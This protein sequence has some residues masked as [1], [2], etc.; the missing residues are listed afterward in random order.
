MLDVIKSS[1]ASIVVRGNLYAA[2][3]VFLSFTSTDAAVVDLTTS[4]F[5]RSMAAFGQ[6]QAMALGA[7]VGLNRSAIRVDSSADRMENNTQV[8][9]RNHGGDKLLDILCRDATHTGL[10]QMVALSLLDVLT[11]WSFRDAP[12]HWVLEYLHAHNYLMY[13]V[14]AVDELQPQLTYLTS[15]EDVAPD[16]LPPLFIYESLMALLL[17]LSLNKVSCERLLAVN[18]VG[19]LAEGT[20]L[21][22]RV[23]ANL[24][25]AQGVAFVPGASTMGASFA[26]AAATD[27]MDWPVLDLVVTVSSVLPHTPGSAHVAAVARLVARHQHSLVRIVRACVNLTQDAARAPAEDNELEMALLK[28]TAQICRIIQFLAKNKA[29]VAPDLTELMPVLFMRCTRLEFARRDRPTQAEKLVIQMVGNI[30]GYCLVAVSDSQAAATANG[31]AAAPALGSPTR[32]PEVDVFAPNASLRAT[33]AAASNNAAPAT[34]DR[35]AVLFDPDLSTRLATGTRALV[36]LLSVLDRMT[37][38]TEVDQLL[39]TQLLRNMLDVIKSSDASIVV[40]GNLY[41]ALLVF[42][43]FTSTDAAVV[44]LTTSMFSRSMAAFGQSQAMALGASVGLN[45]SAIRVDSSADRME[46]NTQVLLRNHGGDKLLDIL[47]RDATHTGLWQMVALSLLDVLTAWSFRDAPRHW[48]LEYLHAHN[49]LMYFVRAV[50]E[51]QPQLTYLTSSEDVAP[52][53]LP[54]LFIYESLMALLLRLSLN[55]VSPNVGSADLC[56]SYMTLQLR[57]LFRSRST[58]LTPYYPLRGKVTFQNVVFAYD[59]RVPTLR[60][61]SFDIPAGKTVGSSGSGKSTILRLLFRFYDVQGGRILIDGVD[62]R[63]MAQSDLRSLIGVV[64]Q[65]TTAQICRIIQFLA[66]NKA[67]VAPDLTELMPVLFM[68]CT[69]LEFARRDRPTQAEKLVIQMVGNIVGYCLVAVSDS[70]AAAT[71]N[72]TAAAPALGSPT[73]RPEVDVFAPNASLRATAAAA[74]NNAAPA[75]ADRPAVLFDPDLST[76]TRDRY[77]STSTRPTLGLLVL[78]MTQ[79]VARV[80]D[81]RKLAQV[82]EQKLR[83]DPA[84]LTVDDWRAYVADMPRGD[85]THQIAYDVIPARKRADV[86]RRAMQMRLRDVGFEAA[87]N[88]RALEMAMTV[89]YLHVRYYTSGA[90]SAALANS[91][92]Q[93]APVRTSVFGETSATAWRARASGRLAMDLNSLRNDAST[94]VPKLKTAIAAIPWAEEN[95]ARCAFLVH[96]CNVLLERIEAFKPPAE[97]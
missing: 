46:N 48:V 95:D 43:S 84:R 47:C 53:E 7:S 45:R 71:A 89:L 20:F 4:M 8:L 49:Y 16:E 37:A 12:R 40:R 65:D 13:F 24:A 6:S 67:N 82:L 54:P 68:R 36:L 87:S 25:A 83:E 22:Y 19:K 15:S 63:H 50:D 97:L 64:P 2:L 77:Y 23:G 86:I 1:D 76:A 79:V 17:R 57:R 29:N 41:A 96:L 81:A 51:L 14:R 18:A 39:L 60:G 66:K 44:D 28:Q 3:L 10:W 91:V 75:T 94:V 93:A 31:T 56:T 59:P 78:Y 9:L 26:G 85:V 92:A 42:L 62:I 61:I 21:S 11:A 30:V 90:V 35:P 72:G 80:T 38:T 69:R 88:V 52:D 70:Q 74:S 73:R 55:K 27:A 5:S 58:T 32:R 34:A 33:A